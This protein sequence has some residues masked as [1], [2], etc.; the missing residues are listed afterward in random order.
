MGIP[1]NPWE[2]LEIPKSSQE[3]AGA[4]NETYR[5]LFEH[6]NIYIYIHT[7][8]TFKIRLTEGRRGVLDPGHLSL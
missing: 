3:F 5:T 6:Y 7:H 2:F 4:Y 1:R 8:S